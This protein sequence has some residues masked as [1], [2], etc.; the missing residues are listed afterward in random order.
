M[1]IFINNI[2]IYPINQKLTNTRRSFDATN[3]VHYFGCYGGTRDSLT[4]F[5]PISP[6]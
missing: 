6:I 5:G 2:F 1:I 4:F 3:V